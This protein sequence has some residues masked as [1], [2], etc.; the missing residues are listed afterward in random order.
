MSN[1]D[2]FDVDALPNDLVVSSVSSS[3]TAE[4][5]VFNIADVGEEPHIDDLLADMAQYTEDDIQLIPGVQ[6]LV[7]EQVIRPAAE[8]T[9][10]ASLLVQALRDVSNVL[11]V[12]TEVKLS[13]ATGM[14]SLEAASI[15]D[16]VLQK[17]L[18]DVA[19]LAKANSEAQVYLKVKNYV[20]DLGKLYEY[21]EKTGVSADEFIASTAK[22]TAL[23]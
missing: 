20:L 19:E 16:P 7:A 2:I 12:S 9:E 18:S 5:P 1:D 17:L 6:E 21:L 22:I 3:G 23:R 13:I 15:N 10:E 14:G 11:Q 4:A 8:L